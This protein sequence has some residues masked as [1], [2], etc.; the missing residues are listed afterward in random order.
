[1]MKPPPLL[2]GAALLFWGWQSGL[3]WVGVSMGLLVELAVRVPGA[4]GFF[5]RRF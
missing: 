2:L 1:M 5:G 4:L 3:P